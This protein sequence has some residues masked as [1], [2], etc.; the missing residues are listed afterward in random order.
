MEGQLAYTQFRE[1]QI[2]SR[3][4]MNMEYPRQRA[5]ASLAV[6]SYS[7]SW[8]PSSHERHWGAIGA[9]VCFSLV[10]A[11]FPNLPTHLVPS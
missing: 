11:Y 10:R 4:G 8:G 7:W 9:W 3:D 5:M 2:P 1:S 6:W